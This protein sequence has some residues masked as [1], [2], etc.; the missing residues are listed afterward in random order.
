MHITRTL[1]AKRFVVG[2]FTL[3]PVC[4]NWVAINHLTNKKYMMA[5]WYVRIDQAIFLTWSYARI[6]VRCSY[7]TWQPMSTI[8]ITLF[9]GD[10]QEPNEKSPLIRKSEKYSIN[11]N[12]SRR[13]M[14]TSMTEEDFIRSPDQAAFRKPSVPLRR[15]PIRW[16]HLLLIE[17]RKCILNI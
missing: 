1:C 16:A 6:W 5:L 17:N 9:S 8:I 10:S 12:Y 4:W 15:S 3:Y 7:W 11:H 14:C 2:F 13:K